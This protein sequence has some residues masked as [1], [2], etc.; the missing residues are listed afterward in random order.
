M[1]ETRGRWGTH[2][3]RAG[4]SADTSWPSH[5]NT[6]VSTIATARQPASVLPRRLLDCALDAVLLGMVV[7]GALLFIVYPLA[8]LVSQSLGTGEGA[9]VSLYA[10]T[11]ARCAPLIW[12]SFFVGVLTACLSTLAALLVSA[13]V[14]FGPRPV[15]IALLGTLLVSMVSPPFVSS[16]AYI[17]LFGRRGL[18]THGVLGLSISPYGWVGVVAM[19]SLFFC[20]INV[21]LLV[22]VMGRVDRRVLEASC[23]L[24]QSSTATFLRVMVPLLRPSLAVCMLLTF[25]RSVADYGTPI[26]IGGSFETVSTQIYLQVVGYSDLAGAA[27]LNVLLL[28]MSV[29]VFV[30]YLAMMRRSERLVAGSATDGRA[31]FGG[32]LFLSG[33]VAGSA[34]ERP[35]LKLTGVLGVA[36][37]AAGALFLVLMALVYLTTVRLAFTKGLG[38]NASFTLANLTHLVDYDLTSLGRSVLYALLSAVIGTAIGALVAYYVQRRRIPL[39]GVLEY[40]VTMPYMLPGTCLGLGY[41]LAFNSEPLR[42]MGTA[43]IIVLSMVFKQLAITTRAF[44]TTM[45]QVSRDLDRAG[46]D[47]GS[48]RLGVLAR[49]LLPNVRGAFLVS[50]VNNFSTSMV[51]YSAVLFLVSPGNK[52]AVFQLFDALSSGRYGQAAMVACVLLAVTLAVNILAG[53]AMRAGRFSR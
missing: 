17:A 39:G 37:Y 49:V 28:A 3:T 40:V 6:D 38:W 14:V 27:V 53:L 7:A 29:V 44:Q 32:G 5:R 9:G 22:S 50:F 41:I 45:G 51:T 12:N 26:V 4:M 21:L 31:G 11:L 10:R 30:A 18:I 13:C 42:L 47:L 34:S 8:C 25:V 48:T 20:A 24:G 23:D 16:L 33:R 46:R 35:A 52:I 15:R 1:S 2:G 43:A 19:Q 36:S